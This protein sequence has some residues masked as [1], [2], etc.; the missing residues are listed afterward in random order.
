LIPLQAI[1]Q[2]VQ[3]FL[4]RFVD[5]DSWLIEQQHVRSPHERE[6]DQQTLKLPA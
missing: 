5:S 1:D 4:T 2:L 6:C 3:S